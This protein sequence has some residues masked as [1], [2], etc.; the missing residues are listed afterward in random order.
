MKRFSN[1]SALLVNIENMFRRGFANQI[2]STDMS[3]HRGCSSNRETSEQDCASG[4]WPNREKPAL[5]RTQ[6]FH[7]D[8]RRVL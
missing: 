7:F 2:C 5:M 3:R 4:W 1:V 6:T 8:Q